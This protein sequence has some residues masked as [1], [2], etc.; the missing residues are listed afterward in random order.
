LIALCICLP[1]REFP[2]GVASLLYMVLWLVNRVASRDFGGRAGPWDF[3]I[4]F[5]ILS[6]YLAAAFAGLDGEQWVAAR[7]LLHYGLILWLVMRAGYSPREMRSV[8]GALVA[9]TLIGLAEGYY[10]VY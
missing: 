5:W 4:G 6:G 7:D 3:L 1:L 10:R 2:K 9:S 8:L